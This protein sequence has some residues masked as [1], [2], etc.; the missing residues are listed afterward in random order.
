MGTIKKIN[1]VVWDSCA[2]GLSGWEESWTDSCGYV[3]FET[4]SEAWSYYKK[5]T[6]GSHL[7]QN[8]HYIDQWCNLPKSV[9]AHNLDVDLC[10]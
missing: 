1:W 7:M 5:H 8:G 6:G 10:V 2:W 3:G 4:L 9:V